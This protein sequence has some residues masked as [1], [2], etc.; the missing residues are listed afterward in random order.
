MLTLIARILVIVGGLNWGLVG[1]GMLLG[2]ATEWNVVHM[3]FGAWPML[4]GLI[5]LL[6]GIGAVIMLVPRR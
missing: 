3:I 4:E 1:L 2:S 5:Y 6:V